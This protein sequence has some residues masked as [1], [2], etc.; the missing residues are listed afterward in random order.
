MM[1]KMMM[2]FL[3]LFFEENDSE[4]TAKSSLLKQREKANSTL[5]GSFKKFC[6][7]ERIEDLFG[8]ILHFSAAIESLDNKLKSSSLSQSRKTKTLFQRWE[9][10]KVFPEQV[11]ASFSQGSEDPKTIGRD[12][13]IACKLKVGNQ[14]DD[15]EIPKDYRV[16][17]VHKKIYNKCGAYHGC[18]H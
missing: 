7:C 14:K 9:S 16:L 10:Q 4:S 6:M 1:K 12:S 18:K 17:A 13:I 3:R 15:P 2:S 5:V 8:C 11:D